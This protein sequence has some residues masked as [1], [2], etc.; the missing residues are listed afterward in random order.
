MKEVK[1][2]DIAANEKNAIVDG[3]F[4]SSLKLSDYVDRGIPVLQGKNITGDKF[5]FSDVR[6]ISEKKAIELSRSKVVERDFLLVKIGSIGYLARIDDLHGYDYA[7]IPA[8]LA[9]IKIDETQIYPEYFIQVFKQDFIK[10]KLLSI[11]SKTAQPAL[12]LSKI[13]S[14]KIPIPDTIDDQKRIAKVLSKAEGLI[15][16]RKESIALLDEYVKSTFLAMF[17]DPVKNEKGWEK[18]FLENLVSSDCPLTYGIVQPGDE[19]S[20]GVPIVRPVDLIDTYVHK[21][22][23]K[24][25]EPRISQQFSRTI[26]KGGELLMCVRGTTGVI[27]IAA[28]EL[29]NCNVSRGLTPIWFDNSYNKYFAFNLFKSKSVQNEIAKK[30]YGIALKQI[31]LSDLRKLFL[32]NPPIELQN[33]FAEIVEKSEALKEKYQESLQELENLYGSLS[34][35]AFKGELSLENVSIDDEDGG[36]GETEDKPIMDEKKEGEEPPSTD[37]P[38][39]AEEAPKGSFDDGKGDKDNSKSPYDSKD[40]DTYEPFDDDGENWDTSDKDWNDE[41]EEKERIRTVRINNLIV[42]NYY[43]GEIAN[44]IKRQFTGF[45]FRFK[46][47]VEMFENMGGSIIYYSTQELKRTKATKDVRTLLFDYLQGTNPELKLTQHFYDAKADIKL[48]HIN[49]R[50]GNDEVL[51]AID[52]REISYDDLCGIYFKIIK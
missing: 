22:Y 27:S 23:L 52:A 42:D 32:I 21:K 19:V 24:R 12:S 20:N 4:G 15:A 36:S 5:I 30:T 45:D 17:G 44:M 11:C 25:I 8:N 9:K 29:R 50:D 7:I 47:L 2:T 35:R 6:Y 26:L 10:Q 18:D 1:L 37:A 51:R 3:P 13:K 49:L 28:Q 41:E 38:P 31:N 43:A 39:E 16:K 40:F 48:E 14:F 33:Q 34:Q 46:E